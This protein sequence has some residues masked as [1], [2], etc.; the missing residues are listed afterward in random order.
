[1]GSTV[2]VMPKF[3]L[4]GF[5]SLVQ[6]YKVSVCMLVPPIALLLAREAVVDKYDMSSLRL[7]I[8]GA[9]PLGPELEKEVSKRLNTGVVQVRVSCSQRPRSHQLIRSLDR[10]TGS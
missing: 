8:S 2:V 5:C 6:K 1:M 3:E 10:H 7:I 4:E 9:A